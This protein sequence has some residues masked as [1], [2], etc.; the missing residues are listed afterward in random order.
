MIIAMSRPLKSNI[1]YP[2]SSGRRNQYIRDLY[3]SKYFCHM[4]GNQVNE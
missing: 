4:Y 2:I 3:L 1:S